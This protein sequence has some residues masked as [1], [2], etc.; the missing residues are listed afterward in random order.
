MI[1][2][3][4]KALVELDDL[5]SVETYAENKLKNVKAKE[6]AL[7]DLK[8]ANAAAE[9]EATS[10]LSKAQILS[11]QSNKLVIEQKEYFKSLIDD[12]AGNDPTPDI[13]PPVPDPLPPK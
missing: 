11:D 10:D 1:L 6:K 4:N 8:A 3:R 12:N 9:L 5:I 7:A 13:V 2:D